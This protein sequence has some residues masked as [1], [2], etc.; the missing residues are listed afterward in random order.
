PGDLIQISVPD[1]D[2]IKEKTER[3]S[4]EGTITLPIAG[5][6]YV[7][8]RT[9]EQATAAIRDKLS[10]LVKEPE[11][12][13][14]VLQYIGR[15]IAVIG[16]VNKRGLYTRTGRNETILDMMGR[17]GGMSEGAGSSVVFMP[18]AHA[19]MQPYVTQLA[20]AQS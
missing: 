17:T 3:V 1:V 13:I 11:V 7:S 16:M 5:S 19:R 6:V 9:E 8:G 2:E 15:Q 18:S 14:I 4:P 10:K 20:A 12:D